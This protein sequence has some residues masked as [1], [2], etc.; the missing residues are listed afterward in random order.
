[1]PFTPTAENLLRLSL[2]VEQGYENVD[3]VE[4]LYCS[5]YYK[6]VPKTFG[7]LPASESTG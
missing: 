3:I 1:M 6:K 5:L 7:R 4:R 2:Y